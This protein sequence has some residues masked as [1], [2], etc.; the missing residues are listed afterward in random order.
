MDRM[1]VNLIEEARLIVRVT[2]DY[3]RRTLLHT[4]IDDVQDA[5]GL[6]T[7]SCSRADMQHLVAVWSRLLLA[8]NE[9]PV[10]PSPGKKALTTAS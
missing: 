9:L 5:F 8:L 2:S 1:N 3:R 10:T 4:L 6:F 7:V